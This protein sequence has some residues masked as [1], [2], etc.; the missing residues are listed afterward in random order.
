VRLLFVDTGTKLETV[1]DLDIKARGG[2]VSSLFHVSDYLARAGHDVYVASDIGQV[3]VSKAGVY[4][5]KEPFGEFDVLIANRGIGSGYPSIKAHKR[6]LWTHDLPHGGF[7]PEPRNVRAFSVVFMSAYAER[8]WRAYYRDIG[9]STI[10]PNGVDKDLFKPADKSWG[11]IIY[12]SAPNRGLEH[13]PLIGEAIMEQVPAAKVHC[14][15][16]LAKL[17]PAEGEDDFDYGIFKD[18][19]VSLH[20]PLPQKHFAK[21]LAR[22]MFMILPSDYPEICSNV[23]LQSLACGTPIVTTGGMGATAEWIEHGRNGLLTEFQNRDYA[24]YPLEI[25]RHSMNI[26]RDDRL[27]RRLRKGA[28]KTKTLTWD[29][30]GAKWNRFLRWI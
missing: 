25:V 26:L 20:D 5:I 19:K 22:A 29:Q 11:E 28:E 17:H 24:I 8:V 18:S 12:A 2:M 14:Y 23:V 1:C 13:M 3:G 27:Y 10:I 16:N 6:V 15:S 30:V 7:I 4:W 21:R 9:K